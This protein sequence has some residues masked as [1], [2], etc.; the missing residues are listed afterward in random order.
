MPDLDLEEFL[1]HLQGPFGGAKD[2]GLVT[3]M[4]KKTIEN[5]LKP[6]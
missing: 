3:T 5:Y 4:T 1:K 6:S 2:V